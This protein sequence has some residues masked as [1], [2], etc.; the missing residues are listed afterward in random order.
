MVKLLSSEQISSIQ[1]SSDELL[2]LP[3]W[4]E[5]E[6]IGSDRLQGFGIHHNSPDFVMDNSS[7]GRKKGYCSHE[8][9]REAV[10]SPN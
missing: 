5:T 8:S 9:L 6:R 3:W 2:R 1:N 7:Q 10:P 4:L